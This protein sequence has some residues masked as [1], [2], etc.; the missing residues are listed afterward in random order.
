MSRTEK[1]VGIN[2]RIY[3]LAISY[4]ESAK[5][6]GEFG[7]EPQSTLLAFSSELLLKCLSSELHLRYRNN[8]DPYPIKTYKFK[9]RGH[10]LLDL[11]NN[12]NKEVK[13][14]I[15]NLHLKMYNCDLT[16]TLED[17]KDVFNECRYSYEQDSL[18]IGI[19]N[20]INLNDLLIKYIDT[21]MT[22]GNYYEKV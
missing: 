16:E 3:R 17:V 15:I 19:G 5:V 6:V 1:Y 20:L 14:D 12:L 21:R 22:Q 9:N 13:S 8:E 7:L 11:F 18:N 2:P 4:Y 10:N